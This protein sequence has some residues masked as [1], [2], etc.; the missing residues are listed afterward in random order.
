[1]E[2][3]VESIAS[4]IQTSGIPMTVADPRLRDCPIISSNAAFQDLTGYSHA[5]I[6]GRN[7]RFLQGEVTDQ[8]ERPS[9]RAAV[10]DLRPCI[11]SLL[12]FKASGEAFHNL[13]IIE[14][15]KLAAGRTLLL[16]CQFGF[17]VDV[18]EDAVTAAVAR[19][20]TQIGRLQTLTKA[21]LPPNLQTALHLKANAAVASVIRYTKRR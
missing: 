19:R 5:A 13:L 21:T 4:F 11:A 17:T 14:P 12:N 9:L 1:M 7:C 2:A 16:G 18:T 8:F 3:D 15:I 6:N 20:Q 10:T